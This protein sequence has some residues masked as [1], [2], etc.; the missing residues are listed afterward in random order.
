V[1]VYANNEALSSVLNRILKPLKLI[2]LK[3][4]IKLFYKRE[5]IAKTGMWRI[6]LNSKSKRWLKSLKAALLMK[7]RILP[8]V[9][10]LVKELKG[11]TTDIDGVIP[12]MLK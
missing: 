2:I 10:V 5:E 4:A 8:G 1:S 12:S 11:T 7:R 6:Y 3:L 9:T